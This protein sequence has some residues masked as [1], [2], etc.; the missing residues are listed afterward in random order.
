MVDR[1]RGGK[2]TLGNGL[3]FGK[4]QRAEEN[5]KQMEKTC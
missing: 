3:E 1:G 2:T 5:R 4:S